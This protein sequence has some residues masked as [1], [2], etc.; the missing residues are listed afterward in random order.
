MKVLL[1]VT[2]VL[3][4]ARFGYTDFIKHCLTEEEYNQR[5]APFLHNKSETKVEAENTDRVDVAKGFQIANMHEMKYDMSL[6]KE[7]RKMKS[8]DDFK[9]G[10]NYRVQ[11]YRER[12][13]RAIWQEFEKSLNMSPSNFVEGAHPLQTAYIEC[14]LT[15]DCRFDALRYDNFDDLETDHITFYGWR[16]TLSVS[17]FQYGPPGSKCSHGKTK[18]GLCIGPPRSE[19]ETTGPS[20]ENNGK[21]EG[22]NSILVYLSISFVS[23]FL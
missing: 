15:T 5:Y 10:V 14:D 6:E 17:D 2:L 18:Q 16:G 7:A 11:F 4:S 3:L 20:A 8:C 1:A 23:L 19:M 12:E 9:H 22:M 13:S 21:S